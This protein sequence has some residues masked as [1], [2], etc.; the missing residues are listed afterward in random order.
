MTNIPVPRFLKR[1]P[2]VVQSLIVTIAGHP[3]NKCLARPSFGASDRACASIMM[4]NRRFVAYVGGQFPG[5]LL[6]A[7]EYAPAT[8]F[9]ADCRLPEDRVNDKLD[10][11]AAQ[12]LRARDE[13]AEE[14]AKEA[15]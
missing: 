11:I 2:A 10:W 12:A 8:Q 5:A 4:S 14:L 1:Y 13:I 6:L 15:A 3:E 7:C 9:H